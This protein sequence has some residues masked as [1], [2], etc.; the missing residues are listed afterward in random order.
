MAAGLVI[1]HLHA[2]TPWHFRS[3]GSSEPRTQSCFQS[4][5]YHLAVFMI[6]EIPKPELAKLSAIVS[7]WKSGDSNFYLKGVAGMRR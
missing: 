1:R 7:H 2:G 3:T 6:F 4:P 5:L